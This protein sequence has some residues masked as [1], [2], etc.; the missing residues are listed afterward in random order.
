MQTTDYFGEIDQYYTFLSG[1]DLTERNFL[2]QM[3]EKEMQK[4]HWIKTK[5]FYY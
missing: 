3:Q 5:E 4:K 1:L 2:R